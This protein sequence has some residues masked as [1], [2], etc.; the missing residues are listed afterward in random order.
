[1]RKNTVKKYKTYQ[2]YRKNSKI[3][4]SSFESIESR[5]DPNYNSDK[6][7]EAIRKELQLLEENETWKLI[8]KYNEQT[9][10]SKWVFCVKRNL[11]GD[12][13]RCK[14]RLCARGFTQTKDVVYKETFSPTT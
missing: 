1:M 10:T 11:N 9:V 13:E 12:I 7:K 6:W 5:E 4:Q 8:D 14:A 3:L 2:F